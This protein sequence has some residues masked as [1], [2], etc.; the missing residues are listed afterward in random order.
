MSVLDQLKARAAEAAKTIV[1]P[2]GQDP[3]VVAAA[4]MA[5]DEKVAKKV[6]VLGTEEE[7]SAACQQAGITERKFESLDYLASDLF[8]EYVAQFTEMRKAKGMTPKKRRRPCRTG[9]ISAP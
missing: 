2:E 1:L 3:R 9:S 8:A 7:I 5:I 4:N 6:I